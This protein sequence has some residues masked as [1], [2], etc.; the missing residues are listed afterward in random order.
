MTD[1]NMR[2]FYSR[3]NRIQ[4]LHSRG[5]SFLAEGTLGRVP[6]P[7]PRGRM[8]AVVR[9]VLFL[10]LGVICLKGILNY[11]VGPELY[12]QRVERLAAG[13]EVDRVGAALMWADPA[14][15]WVADQL[16]AYMPPRD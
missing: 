2:D 16:R 10:A 13:D 7:A 5:Y 1:P 8:L 6:R 12:D 4:R 3:V 11:Q 15:V 9:S 14:S